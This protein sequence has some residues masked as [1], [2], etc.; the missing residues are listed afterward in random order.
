METTAPFLTGSLL[1]VFIGLLAGAL[2]GLLAS[3]KQQRKL[4]SELAE[5]TAALAAAEAE[6]RLLANRGH[7]DTSVLQALSP[8]TER[9]SGL[10]RQVALLERD[11]VEQYGQLAQQ[12]Q[13][14]K[15][16]DALLLEA[17]RSLAS[18]LRST[19]ARG[20]WGEVQ[21]RRIVESAGLLT[22][23]DFSEQVNRAGEEGTQ[24]PDLV[25]RLP[26]G[27]ELV[28]DA[29]VPLSAFLDAQ[30]SGT[31][32]EAQLAMRQHAKALRAHVDALAAKRYWDTSTVS[33]EVVIC[34]L[35]AESILS[36][37][38]TA[39]GQLLDHALE[40]GVVLASPVS[41]LAVLKAVGH[42]WRQEMLTED[43]RQLF[44][45]ASKLYERL[46][47]FAENIGKLGAS[48][49][50]S[51]ERYNAVVGSFEAR[52]LPAARKLNGLDPDG[53]KQPSPVETP[54]RRVG[55]WRGDEVTG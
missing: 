10:Q 11:R 35:P 39:D 55:P 36:A 6:S 54:L 25:V 1:G 15:Q 12:L 22:H 9:L 28:V 38:L 16:A 33:P 48:L 42:T 19:T 26:G 45:V 27:K 31:D 3:A 17:T 4:R 37:A 40:R 49:G 44:D 8:L 53:L 2:I 5:T 23:V 43:A 46:R 41:L 47:V 7:E 21:L 29:K 32:A 51:V 13:D 18:S 34:F 14:A 20:R 50:T 52:V 24:R 30:E